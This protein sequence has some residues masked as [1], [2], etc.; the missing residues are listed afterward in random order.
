MGAM[1]SSDRS[2]MAQSEREGWEW[3]SATEGGSNTKTTG[4]MVQLVVC[5]AAVCGGEKVRLWK[6]GGPSDIHRKKKKL[7]KSGFLGYSCSSPTP[8]EEG[9]K[10]VTG[11]RKNRQRGSEVSFASWM[12]RTMSK[13]SGHPR[14]P[15]IHRQKKC[16]KPAGALSKAPPPPTTATLSPDSQPDTPL[17]SPKPLEKSLSPFIACYRPPR[18]SPVPHPHPHPHPARWQFLGCVFG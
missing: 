8:P 9:A 3:E 18:P 6:A 15:W 11:A 17:I 7:F 5:A 1:W 12:G 13:E 10:K 2:V 14:R 16:L 4:W